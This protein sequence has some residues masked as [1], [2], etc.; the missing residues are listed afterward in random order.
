MK[1]IL[2]DIPD[3][4]ETERLLVSPY[5]NGDGEEFFRL[6]QANYDHLQEELSEIHTIKTVDDAEEYVRHKKVAWLSRERL[7]PKIIENRPA[8]WSGS[9]GSSQGGSG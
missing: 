5:E 9:C 8:G 7:V 4:F 3:R 2:L 1:P 6:L